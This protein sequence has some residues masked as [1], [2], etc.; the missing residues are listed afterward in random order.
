MC[1]ARRNDKVLM[2]LAFFFGQ[3]PYKR[4]LKVIGPGALQN[5]VRCAA[6]QHLAVIHRNQL[7]ETGGF[8]HI[9][10]CDQHGHAALGFADLVDQFPELST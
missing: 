4:G 10:G 5:L 7:V 1:G 3:Q 6:C 2:A 9:G 8:I